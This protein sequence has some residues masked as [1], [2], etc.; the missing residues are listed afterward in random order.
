VQGQPY[1]YHKQSFASAADSS[2]W[3]KFVQEI[4]FVNMLSYCWNWTNQHNVTG[5]ENKN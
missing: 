5:L 2:H 4:L 3:S 1:L